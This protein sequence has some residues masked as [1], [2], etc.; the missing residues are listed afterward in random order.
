MPRSKGFKLSEEHK[1]KLSESRKGM[2]FSE[3]HKKAL[4]IAAKKRSKLRI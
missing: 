4:S 3:S 2:R 1:N